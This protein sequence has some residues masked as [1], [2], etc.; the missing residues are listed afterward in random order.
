MVCGAEVWSVGQ[1]LARGAEAQR[2]DPVVVC[3]AEPQR[4]CG[5]VGAVDV[6]EPPLGVQ[7]LLHVFSFLEARDLLSAAQVDKVTRPGERQG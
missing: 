1:A 4:R 6:M 3:G 5:A 7:E 2:A